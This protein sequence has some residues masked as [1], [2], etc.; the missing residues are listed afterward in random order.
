MK[1]EVNDKCRTFLQSDTMILGVCGQVC[2]N[3]QNNKFAISLQ[4]FKR[5]VSDAVEFLH[6]EKHES[7]LQ[8]DTNTF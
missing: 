2:P 8:A 3:Y 4:H 7:L 1:D 5:E 6:A